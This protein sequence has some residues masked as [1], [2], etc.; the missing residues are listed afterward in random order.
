MSIWFEN[1]TVEEI[2]QRCK[3]SLSDHLGIVFTEIGPHSLTATMP[4]EQQTMQPMGI[5]H[6]G[7]SAA[8]AETVASAAANYCVDLKKKR[9]VGLNLFT[10][11][12][13]AVKQGFVKAIAKPLHLGKSTQVWEIETQDSEKRLI[14]VSRLTLAV[15]DI[16]SSLELK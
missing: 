10:N 16:G 8:L 13:K 2:T 3:N 15:I 12:I 5:L 6:G 7:A 9:C 11:H 4:I 1:I 14:S